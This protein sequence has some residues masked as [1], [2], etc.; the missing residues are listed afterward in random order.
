VSELKQEGFG[1]NLSEQS[2]TVG[3]ADEARDVGLNSLFNSLSCGSCGSTALAEDTEA[4]IDVLSAVPKIGLPTSTNMASE[5]QSNVG[6]NL[7]GPKMLGVA[8]MS[9]QVL[10][11]C[12]NSEG[13][14]WHKLAPLPRNISCHHLALPCHRER[15]TDDA[16]AVDGIT[17]MSS[18]SCQNP[19]THGDSEGT[20]EHKLERIPSDTRCNKL[21]TLCCDEGNELKLL[22]L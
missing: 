11:A 17:E 5:R 12:D 22:L 14:R 19:T 2:T 10:A 4:T 1:N 15:E 9:R 13:C 8:V 6:S 7:G 3:S 20:W 21:A 16:V 18:H